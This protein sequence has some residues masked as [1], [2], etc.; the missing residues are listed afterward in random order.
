MPPVFF[1]SSRATTTTTRAGTRPVWGASRSLIGDVPRKW[2]AAMQSG[3]RERTPWTWGPVR[4]H[5]PVID[6]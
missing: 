6:Q 1:T 5:T 4:A 3:A 2:T